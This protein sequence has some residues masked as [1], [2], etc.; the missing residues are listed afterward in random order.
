MNNGLTMMHVPAVWDDVFI[1]F[2]IL[3]SVGTSTYRRRSHLKKADIIDSA[4]GS[5][6]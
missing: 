6:Q 4:E 1:G 5:Q 2:V 3:V